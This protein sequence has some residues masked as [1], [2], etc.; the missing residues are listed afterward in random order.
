MHMSALYDIK[1]KLINNGVLT[2]QGDT[3][4]LQIVL[5]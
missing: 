2:T 4:W 5:V 3:V 1:S